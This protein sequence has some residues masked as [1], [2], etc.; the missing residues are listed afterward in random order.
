VACCKG[1]SD[2]TELGYLQTEYDL[3][4]DTTD[5]DSGS[6]ANV[7]CRKA[8]GGEHARSLAVIYAGGIDERH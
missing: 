4:I 7:S 8:H 6:V 2:V 3:Q 1:S 5:S